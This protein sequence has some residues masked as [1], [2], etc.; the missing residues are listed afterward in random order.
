[1]LRSFYGKQG[2]FGGDNS[3][4]IDPSKLMPYIPQEDEKFQSVIPK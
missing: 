1:M 4:S 2:T 3:N